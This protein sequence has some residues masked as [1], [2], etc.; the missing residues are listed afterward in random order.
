MDHRSGATSPSPSR[1]NH[2]GVVISSSQS[3]ATPFTVDGEQPSPEPAQEAETDRHSP[4]SLA[5]FPAFQRKPTPEPLSST[6]VVASLSE[7]GDVQ[8]SPHSPDLQPCEDDVDTNAVS[9]PVDTHGHS[10]RSPSPQPRAPSPVPTPTPTPTPPKERT[11]TPPPPSPPP[12]PKVK[13]SLKDFAMRRKK[14]KEEEEMASALAK[15]A[16]PPATM[17]DATEIQTSISAATGEAD[18]NGTGAEI[19]QM[20]VEEGDD[21][22]SLGEVDSKTTSREPEEITGIARSQ[23]PEPSGIAMAVGNQEKP[24]SAPVS[25]LAPSA[26]NGVIEDRSSSAEPASKSASPVDDAQAPVSDISSPEPKIKED[27]AVHPVLDFDSRAFSDTRVEVVDT[28]SEI[29]L[30]FE[31]PFT[32]KESFPRPP[33]NGLNTANHRDPPG[34]IAGATRSSSPPTTRRSLH[35]EGEITSGPPPKQPAAFVPRAHTPPTQPRSFNVA[36]NS[37]TLSAGSTSGPARRPSQTPTARPSIPLSRPPPIGPRALRTQLGATPSY[38]S[39]R[40]LPG[41]QFIPRGPSADRDRQDWDRDRSWPG[42]PRPRGRGAG[43]GWGR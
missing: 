38:P 18:T 23:S 33:L 10:P 17:E 1:Q 4:Q 42:H 21:R 28:P 13:M 15:A 36:P 40:P 41:S 8:E 31:K 5:L 16:E 22:A 9:A 34:T 30:K 12:P 19:T 29:S 6:P 2:N 43:G 27:D 37:P 3:P 25:G 39:N 26:P 32:I 14:Q 35:E 24:S 11:P 20:G 7:K